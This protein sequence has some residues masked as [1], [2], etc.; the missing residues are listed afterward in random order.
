[1][2]LAPSS[3]VNC[4]SDFVSRVLSFL[5]HDVRVGTKAGEQ[6]AAR[7]SVFRRSRAGD[8]L[9]GAQAVPPRAPATP[10]LRASRTMLPGRL[11]LGMP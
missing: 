6:T 9:S 1:M 11:E 2:S 5:V 3:C 8:C 10:T 7:S 4:E